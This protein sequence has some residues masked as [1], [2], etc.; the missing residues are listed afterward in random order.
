MTIAIPSIIFITIFD[1]NNNKII[2]RVSPCTK[3]IGPHNKDIISIIYGS[4]LGNTD[5]EYR[6]DGHGTR[7][8]FSK[9]SINIDYLLWIHSLVSDCGYCNPKVPKIQSRIGTK[10]KIRYIIRFHTFTYSSFN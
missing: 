9:E 4:L 7:I 6:K 2:T 8:S 10:G 1:N 5:A 3:R